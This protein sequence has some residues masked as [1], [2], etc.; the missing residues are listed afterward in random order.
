MVGI[1][2]TASAALLALAT[3]AAAR[4]QAPSPSP[5]RVVVVAS[6]LETPWS[7]AFAPDGRLFVAER[8]GR[9]RVIERGRLD[10][11]PWATVP[12]ADGTPRNFETGLMGLAVDP[13]FRAQPF[14]YICYSYR[15]PDGTVFNRI[16]RLRERDAHGVEPTTLLDGMPGGPYHNGCRLKF[17]PDGKLYATTGD[18]QMDSLA[19]DRRSPAGKVLR[20]NDD[21]TIPRDN[22]FPGS[23]V[24]SLGHRNAQGM[25][26]EPRT[27]RLFITEHGTGGVD[28]LNLIT[29][30]RNYGWPAARGKARDSRYVDAAVVFV[31]APAGAAFVSG[32]RYPGL[33]GALVAGSLSGQRL[34][35]FR[36]QPGAPRLGT[37]SLLTGYGRLR[38]VVEG[39]DSL[40]Y[41]ATSNRDGRG[42]RGGDDDRILRL[43]PAEPPR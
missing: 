7:L 3:V 4:H 33:R 37:D 25:A 42:V 8:P 16:A 32:S 18:A 22:P 28:E 34:L 11:V 9:I 38:D 10:P 26:W 27:N 2:W 40:L 31:A 23:P 19:Q 14:I 21:G 5:F 30:G 36:T 39:P 12:A 15:S 41:V 35:L 17:G 24:W 6:G 1:R 20:L 13:R 43:L 29:K